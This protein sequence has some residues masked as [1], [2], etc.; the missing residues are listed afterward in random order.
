MAKPI[1]D[2]SFPLQGQGSTA[3]VRDRLPLRLIELSGCTLGPGWGQPDM[4]APTW[5]LYLDLDP[6]AEVWVRGRCTPLEPGHLYVVP[7]WL[8]WSSRCRGQVRHYNAMLDLPSLPRDRVAACCPEAVLLAAPDDPL[9]TEWLALAVAQAGAGQADAAMLARGHALVWA[10][11]ARY[12]ASL[13]PRLAAL[14]PAGR[15]DRFE[16]LQHWVEQ[17]LDQSLPRAALARAA[18]CS[19]AELARRFA[20][21]LGT[22]PGRWLRDR[23]VARAAELLR[24]TDLP[25]EA[26]AARCGL[27]DRSRFTRVFGRA[28]GCGPGAYRRR[29]RAG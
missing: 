19:E 18:G 16:E 9:A 7:A 4:T 13:G 8:R 25:V 5:R 27:G 12:F 6:G 21:S 14:V 3:P 17:R 2:V 11:L 10:A 23:R 15:D 28:L 22:S 1:T 20:G 26:V 29:N 24:T